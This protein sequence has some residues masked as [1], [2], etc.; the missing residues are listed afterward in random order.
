VKRRA[1]LFL[2]PVLPGR[3]QWLRVA[4]YR[5]LDALLDDVSGL[6]C[7]VSGNQF[8]ES[9]WPIVVWAVGHK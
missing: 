9:G 2:W 8:G 7:D 6:D 5:D 1:S 3:K 4:M